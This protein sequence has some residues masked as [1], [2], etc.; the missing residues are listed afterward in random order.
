MF[1][2][3]SRYKFIKLLF[4]PPPKNILRKIYLNGL[5]LI[6]VMH[7]ICKKSWKKKSIAQL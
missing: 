3:K 6:N 5:K 2:I 4:T 1:Q 7:I